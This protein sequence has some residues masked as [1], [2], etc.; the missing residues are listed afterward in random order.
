MQYLELGLYPVDAPSLLVIAHQWRGKV[1]GLVW[2][3]LAERHTAK[4]LR[5]LA[6]Q[7]QVSHEAVRRA[8]KAADLSLAE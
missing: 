5:S 6:K 7:Y 4:S 1:S 3:E 8:L 2:S